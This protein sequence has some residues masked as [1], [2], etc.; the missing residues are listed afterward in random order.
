LNYLSG[1]ASSGFFH[2][3]DYRVLVNRYVRQ[4]LRE[5]WRRAEPLDYVVLQ[6]AVYR[7][8]ARGCIVDASRD[9]REVF[10][11]VAKCLGLQL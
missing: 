9:L 10:L 3:G 4:R 1:L 5:G 2:V 6:Q 11:G 7:M 8:L